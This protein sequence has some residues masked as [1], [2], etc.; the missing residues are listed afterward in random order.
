MAARARRTSAAGVPRA[1]E[2]A[3]ADA[4]HRRRM[5]RRHR[6]AEA[7]A[8]SPSEAAQGD[9]EG[10]CP[11][12]DE[13]PRD[14]PSWLECTNPTLTADLYC[15][16]LPG[17]L[18]EQTNEYYDNLEV[19]LRWRRELAAALGLVEPEVVESLAIELD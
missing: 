17:Y 11:M 3:G 19:W 15:L 5:H 1:R 4:A 2:G 16:K 9:G 10:W 7:G 6:D 12:T 18:K 8:Q 14:V 13:K